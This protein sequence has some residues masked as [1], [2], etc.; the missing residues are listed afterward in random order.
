MSLRFGEPHRRVSCDPH[1]TEEKSVVPL[2]GVVS[3][4]ILRGDSKIECLLEEVVDDGLDDDG[5][6][7]LVKK[8]CSF[9]H[10]VAALSLTHKYISKVFNR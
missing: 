7:F 8:A 4:S 5:P 1:A 9:L 10:M 6:F 3:S 2:G